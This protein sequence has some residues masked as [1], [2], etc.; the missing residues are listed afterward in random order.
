MNGFRHEPKDIELLKQ[1]IRERLARVCAG[2]SPDEKEA[3][4]NKVTMNELRFPTG[5]LM[6]DFAI[7][8]E[9]QRLDIGVSRQR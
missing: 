4:V 6:S 1:D 3:L 9:A 5:R 2:W 7:E 8:S